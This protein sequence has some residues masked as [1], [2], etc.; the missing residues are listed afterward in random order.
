M[1]YKERFKDRRGAYG[2]YNLLI[3]PKCRLGKTNPFPEDEHMKQLYAST[4][5]RDHESRFIPFVERSIRVFRKFRRKRI[6]RFIQKGRILDIGCGR[7]KFLSL[8]QESGWEVYGLEFNEETAWHARNVLGLDIRTGSI[9][10]VHFDGAF[11]DVITLWHVLEHLPDPVLTMEECRRI[12]KP[13]GLLVIAVP[14]FDSLQAHIS[15]DDWFHLDLPYHLYHFNDKNLN[16]FLRKFAF[17]IIKVKQFSL[18]FNPFGYLQSF[19]NM[20]H[21]EHNLLYSILKSGSL[22]KVLSHDMKRFKLYM[23]ILISMVLLPLYTP[24]SFGFSFVE[25]VLRRGGTIEIYALKED[26][27]YL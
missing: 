26:Q 7:G 11:F 13:G 2:S 23:H 12:L 8:M 25:S 5:Y 4:I 3:C 21:I 27:G 20:S 19:L 18:E 24:L 6:E 1:R 16:L 15:G 9:A 22:R 17:E 10:D 14:N